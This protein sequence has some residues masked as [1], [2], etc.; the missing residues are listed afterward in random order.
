MEVPQVG[1]VME[2][3]E[4]AWALFRPDCEGRVINDLRR[5]PDGLF[6]LGQCRESGDGLFASDEFGTEVSGVSTTILDRD[7]DLQGCDRDGSQEVRCQASDMLETQ[8]GG[9][10]L[11][12]SADERD[13]RAGMLVIRVPWSAGESAALVSIVSAAGEGCVWQHNRRLC[14]DWRACDG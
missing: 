8:G 5:Q 10:L 6:P 3:R 12:R 13:G 2:G 1:G 11:D 9:F 7:R 4:L 14:H